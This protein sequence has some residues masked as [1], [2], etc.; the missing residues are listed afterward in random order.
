MV[1]DFQI[2]PAGAAATQNAPG[3]SKEAPKTPKGKVARSKTTST[4]RRGY[5]PM[6]GTATYG[7]GPPIPINSL[8]DAD[9]PAIP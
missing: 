6:T 7:R 2:M 9:T 8:V 3:P 4:P 1:E 5:Q